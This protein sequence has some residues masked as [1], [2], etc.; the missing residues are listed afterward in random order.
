MI[1]NKE[2]E[3]KGRKVLPNLSENINIDDKPA[4]KLISEE[5][6][7]NKAWLNWKL[8]QSRNWLEGRANKGV[9]I[10]VMM[11]SKTASNELIKYLRYQWPLDV[12]QTYLYEIEMKNK[13]IYRVFYGDFNS[14]SEGKKKLDDLPPEIRSNS[15]YLHSIYRM[16][17]TLL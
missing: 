12:G 13:K 2:I 17:K 11:R 15:P 8:Q 4:N 3:E 7:D 5:P 16:K 10:Q 1:K 14:L 9:S 6:V